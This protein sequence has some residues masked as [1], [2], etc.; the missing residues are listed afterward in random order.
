M[1]GWIFIALILAP[2]VLVSLFSSDA[3]GDRLPAEAEE[4]V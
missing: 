3:K 4:E 2:L 1:D